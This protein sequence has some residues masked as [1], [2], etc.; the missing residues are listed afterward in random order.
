MP[1]PLTAVRCHPQSSGNTLADGWEP[2]TGWWYGFHVHS[3]FFLIQSE[4]V[5]QRKI[6]K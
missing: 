2:D 6:E 3:D 5:V 1:V 4:N